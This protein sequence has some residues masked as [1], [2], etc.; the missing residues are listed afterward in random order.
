MSQ[1]IER[2]FQAKRVSPQPDAE[3]TLPQINHVLVTEDIVIVYYGDGTVE[4]EWIEKMEEIGL[5]VSQ[6]RSSL[7]ESVQPTFEARWSNLT[8]P[9]TETIRIIRSYL[10][11]RDELAKIKNEVAC[12]F[13]ALSENETELL[14]TAVENEQE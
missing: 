7:P 2:L 4:Y 3:A 1:N 8:A 9:T 12:C 11:A 5:I 6:L 13:P 10:I 14:V